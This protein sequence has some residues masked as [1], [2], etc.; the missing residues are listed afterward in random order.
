MIDQIRTVA[1]LGAGIIGRGMIKNL[2][3]AGFEL[4]LYNRSLTKLSDFH[5]PRVEVCSSPLLAAT[6]ADVVIAAVSDDAASREAW[7]GPN[8]AVYGMHQRSVAIECSTLSLAYIDDWCSRLSALGV[9]TVDCPVTGSKSGADSG[10]LSL[11]FG[12]DDALRDQLSSVLTA[13]GDDVYVFGAAGQGARFKLAYNMMGGTILVALAEALGL[14]RALDV[15]IDVALLA[16]KQNGWGGPVTSGMSKAMLAGEHGDVNC[17]LAL[18]HKDLECA[19]AAGQI[20]G[21]DVPAASAAMTSMAQAI[22]DGLGD[23]DMSG[24]GVVYKVES[25]LG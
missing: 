4:R 18:L 9:I 16:M 22:R 24:V 25:R 11:F 14:L 23:N 8:G 19:L 1:V 5:G 20:T 3:Q 15:N 21:C 12:G 6:G 10:T 2:I 7:F 13:I 17:R